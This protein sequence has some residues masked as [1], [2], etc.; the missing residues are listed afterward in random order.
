MTMKCDTAQEQI[1]LA[2]YGE[3]ADDQKH[4]LEQHLGVCENCRQELEGAQ[5]L[6]RAMALYPVEEPSPN[7]VARTRMRLEEALDAMPQGGWLLRFTQG[8]SR[9]A[10]RLRTA[11]I[12]ASVVLIAGLGAGAYGGYHAGLH[13]HETTIEAEHEVAAPP[14]QPAALHDAGT[15][16]APE[17]SND[18]QLA[19]IASVS[20]ILA[21]PGSDKVEVRYNRLVPVSVHGSPNDPGIRQLLVL[22]AKNRVNADV[23]DNSVG[24]LATG[25]RTGQLCSDRMVRNA[26]MVSLLYDD[27]PRVRLEAL[28]GLQPYVADDVKVRDAVLEALMRDPNADVR[29]H[30][31]ELLEPVGADSSVREVLH[32]VAKRDDNPQIRGALQQVLSQAVQV[33]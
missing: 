11:P 5:A 6:M 29:A 18:E 3:L 25:C 21:E 8:F 27:S 13:A 1:A 16:V 22:G 12:A 14:A 17:A 24:L 26:L 33:Q 2:V 9:G 20:N 30:A 31:V 23:R 7:L 4:Q 10:H 28:D 32:T 19:D 15:T